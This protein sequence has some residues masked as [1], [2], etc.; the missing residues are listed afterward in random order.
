MKF[1]HYNVERTGGPVALDGAWDGPSW[2]P[3][4]PL[5]LARHMGDVPAH[6]PY[7]RAKLL[8]DEDHVHVIFRVEDRYVR[9]VQE[10]QGA[11]CRDSCVEFFFTPGTNPTAGYFNLETNCGGSMLFHHQTEPRGDHVEIARGDCD[12]IARLH[13]LPETVDPEITDPVTWVLQYRLPLDILAHHS[14]VVR[15]APGAVWRAN[16]YKCADSTSH[17]HWLTW[18]PVERPRP[19][20][21]VPE[22]F[23]RLVFG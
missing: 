7:V 12:R 10:H 11:V 3:V 18:S 8:Y 9:A 15:P 6:R 14:E 13:S 2:G 4:P 20:F 16:F 22:C 23:G 19:D 5:H 21:H 1:E 17:P